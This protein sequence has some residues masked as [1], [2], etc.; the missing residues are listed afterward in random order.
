MNRTI[1]GYVPGGQLLLNPYTN[2]RTEPTIWTYDPDTAL[3]G[4][5][6][7]CYMDANGDWIPDSCEIR[8][9]DS[10]APHSICN[11][12]E[13]HI[14]DDVRM[15]ITDTGWCSS[16]HSLYKWV[17]DVHMRSPHEDH[18]LHSRAAGD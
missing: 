5:I 16:V 15:G 6:S 14:F 4:Q 18:R 7:C 11:V 13:G 2:E 1:V 9:L 12:H 17:K 8:A 3:P 10:Y